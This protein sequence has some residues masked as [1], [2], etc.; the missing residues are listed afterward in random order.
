MV[1]CKYDSIS[2][3]IFGP[4]AIP[5]ETPT[6]QYELK[7]KLFSKDE[8]KDVLLALGPDLLDEENYYSTA[9]A[10]VKKEKMK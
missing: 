8:N 4:D 10:Q 9:T 3:Y 7:L 5:K 2:L 6:G 1:A